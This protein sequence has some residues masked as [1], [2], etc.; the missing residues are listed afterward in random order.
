MELEA[1]IYLAEKRGALKR[2]CTAA[3]ILLILETYQLAHREP[4]GRAARVQ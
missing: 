1:M 3:S 2:K 4:F